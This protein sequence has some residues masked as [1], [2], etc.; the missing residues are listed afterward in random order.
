MKYE[1]AQ[2]VIKTHSHLIG[3]INEKGFV[4][5]ELIMVPQDDNK[6]NQCI[7]SYIQTKD[8][9]RSIEPYIKDELL[10]W[11][12]DTKHLVESNVLFFQEIHK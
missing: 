6:R 10:V 2:E 7:Q 1:E 11:A 12:I 4:I 8:A 5:S 3:K 9:T